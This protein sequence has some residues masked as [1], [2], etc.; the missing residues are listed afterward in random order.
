MGA[1]AGDR[2]SFNCATVFPEPRRAILMQGSLHAQFSARDLILSF[3]QSSGRL[4]PCALVA[5]VSP[6]NQG[7]KSRSNTAKTISPVLP[8]LH[9]NRC[10]P[11]SSS[12][13]RP[14]LVNVESMYSASSRP[15]P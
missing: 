6:A 4:K 12:G 7:R 1:I 2:R 11:M 9:R 5:A 14:V 3:F 10:D 13:T 15:M 8:G